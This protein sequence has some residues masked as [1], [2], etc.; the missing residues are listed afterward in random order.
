MM[1]ACAANKVV[2]SKSSAM[3]LAILARIFA[4]A[5]ATT[6]ASAQLAREICSTLNSWLESHMETA[7]LLPLISLKVKG[8]TN[9]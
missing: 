6:K 8:V 7:T 2:E 4:V 3:P 1:G 5:G 9:C